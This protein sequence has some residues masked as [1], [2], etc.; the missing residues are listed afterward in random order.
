MTRLAYLCGAGLIFAIGFYVGQRHSESGRPS[1]VAVDEKA[2]IQNQNLA[3]INGLRGHG[4]HNLLSPSP[5][6][7]QSEALP[8]PS[9]DPSQGIA[10][11]QPSPEDIARQESEMIASMR[12]KDSE[13]PIQERS[14]A[15]LAAELRESLKQAGAPQAVIDDMAERMIPP[16]PSTDVTQAEHTH[17]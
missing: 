10:S 2:A 12:T 8:S 4:R 6:S 15:E 5:V 9:H 14:T 7:A 16:T 17:P 11:E 3:G 1:Q 13:F